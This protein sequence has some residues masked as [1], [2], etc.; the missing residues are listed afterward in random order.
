M[1]SSLEDTQQPIESSCADLTNRMP[2]AVTSCFASISNSLTRTWHCVEDN[3]LSLW[4]WL[5]IR[6]CP[7]KD[8]SCR[9]SR[10]NIR[11][12]QQPTITKR[13]SL[14]ATKSKELIEGRLKK[15][16]SMQ[17]PERQANPPPLAPDQQSIS[18]VSTLNSRQPS[19]ASGASTRKSL[20]SDTSSV[21]SE[22]SQNEGSTSGRPPVPPKIDFIETGSIFGGRKRHSTANLLLLDN[23]RFRSPGQPTVTTGPNGR[24]IRMSFQTGFPPMKY[25]NTPEEMGSDGPEEESEQQPAEQ[26]RSHSEETNS[27][28]NRT[29]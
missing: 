5:T 14:L 20:I 13:S 1:G 16:R 25:Q 18:S 15:T 27:L 7:L 2:G 6:I 3:T 11:P 9:R 24:S 12:T 4:H 22:G 8:H 10:I 19:I 29:K 23:G 17:N 26:S 28:V 21:V